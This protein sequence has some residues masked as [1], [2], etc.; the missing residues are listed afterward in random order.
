MRASAIVS[1]LLLCCRA[2]HGPPAKQKALH[3]PRDRLSLWPTQLG[4]AFGATRLEYEKKF[5]KF[6]SSTV[7]L[8]SLLSKL[9][10]DS[11]LEFP[12]LWNLQ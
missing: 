3:L 8:I 1:H 2:L 5:K 6:P 11:L 12:Q 7:T 4:T 9:A 10:L